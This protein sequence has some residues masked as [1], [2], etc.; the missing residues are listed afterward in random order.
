MT[1]HEFASNL[2]EGWS[3]VALVILALM[4][5]QTIR[6]ELAAEDGSVAEIVGFLLA[7]AVGIYFGGF[8]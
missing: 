8:R 7:V 6:E 1:L 5:F 2:W 4:V 3:V